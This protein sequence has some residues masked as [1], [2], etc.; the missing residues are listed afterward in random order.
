MR[1]F[2][3]ALRPVLLQ[4]L[5]SHYTIIC[6]S[7]AGTAALALRLRTQLR[8]G[9]KEQNKL[10][11]A[12]IGQV[13]TSLAEI[14]ISHYSTLIFCSSFAGTAALALRL[15]TQLRLGVKEQNKLSH[16]QIG[17][18]LTSLAEI[19]ISHYSTLIFCSSFTG[20]AALALRLRTQHR[21]DV[22]ELKELSSGS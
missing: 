8:R 11:H 16:A 10:S 20:T 19:L 7:F 6:S 13:L 22:K 21:L 5:I 15:H 1:C 4:I 14:L 18:V 12:Q 17:Q 3:R 9:V 2:E